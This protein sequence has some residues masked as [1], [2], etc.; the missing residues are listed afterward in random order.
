MSKNLVF[1]FDGKLVVSSRKVA[2]DFEKRHDNVL[3]KIDTKIEEWQNNDHLK[4]KFVE[5]FIS[6]TYIDS[7][8][9]SRK[10]YLLNKDGFCFIVLGFTGE[11]ADEFKVEY[12]DEF[13]RMEAE[14]KTIEQTKSQEYR[15]FVAQL[16]GEVYNLNKSLELLKESYGDLNI[17]TVHEL[18]ERLRAERWWT[19]SG[20]SNKGL[21]EL[22]LVILDGE[23]CLSKKALDRIRRKVYN[24]NVKIAYGKFDSEDLKGKEIGFKIKNK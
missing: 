21:K 13:N 22:C 17:E 9:E 5:Y 18:K 12:I 8:G 1:D 23:I 16:Y 19:D 14:L 10:E 4:N 15:D 2:E 3:A 24:D 20:I 7:K 11:K 6:S